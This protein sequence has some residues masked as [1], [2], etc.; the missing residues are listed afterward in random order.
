[1]GTSEIPLEDMVARYKQVRTPA[2]A[3]IL[4]Q[5]GLFHQVLPPSIQAIAPGCGWPGRH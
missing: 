5:K 2:I 4:D 3:D 1:M